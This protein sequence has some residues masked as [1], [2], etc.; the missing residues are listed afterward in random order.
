MSLELNKAIITKFEE[1][2]AGAHNSFY[3]AV[4]GRMFYGRAPDETEFPYAI[5]TGVLEKPDNT[6]RRDGRRAFF[7]IDIY[8][9]T[10]GIVEAETIRGYC[11]TLFNRATV[12]PTGYENTKVNIE[13]L[14]PAMITGEEE[15]SPW[16]TGIEFWCILQKSP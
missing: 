3:T 5:F 12:S 2:T 1:V 8:S 6:L 10:P 4:G 13:A 7:Q 16:R 11:E 14:Y 15:D 9:E